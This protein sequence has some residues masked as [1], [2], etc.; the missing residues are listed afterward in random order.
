MHSST[1]DSFLLFFEPLEG[2]RIVPTEIKIAHNWIDV[3]KGDILS[4]R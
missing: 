1:L 4:F 3:L 2:D